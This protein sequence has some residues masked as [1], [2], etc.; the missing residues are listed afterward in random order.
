MQTACAPPPIPPRRDVFPAHEEM[1]TTCPEC[2]AAGEG[3]FCARCGSSLKPRPCPT[4][5]AELP[6]G[7]RYCTACG[8]AV[9]G[10]ERRLDI[11]P[12]PE[13]AA[14]IPW[15][16]ATAAAI[17]FIALLFARGCEPR[18]GAPAAGGVIAP[19]GDPRAIDLSAM[20]P[21]D[22]AERLYE[23]VMRLASAGDT[24]QAREFAPMA[25]AAYERVPELTDDE[26]YHIAVLHLFQG[27]IA[28]AEAHADSVLART[29]DHLLALLVSAQARRAAGDSEGAAARYRRFLEAYPA[30]IAVDREEYRAHAPVLAEGRDEARSF[31]R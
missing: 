4:C 22:A 31:L 11:P 23:R 30:E 3:N 19:A 2:G 12:A 16:V 20:T 25:L 15:V 14:R 17:A 9:G 21:A 10:P 24:A 29:P 27:S 1:S 13:R 8:A 26:H 28:R 6:A 18:D 7:A 5:G